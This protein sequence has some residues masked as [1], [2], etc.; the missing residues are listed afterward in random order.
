MTKLTISDMVSE[1]F[2]FSSSAPYKKLFPNTQASV[3]WYFASSPSTKAL[4]FLHS[5]TTFLFFKVGPKKPL[6]VSSITLALLMLL[7]QLLLQLV[8]LLVLLL[9]VLR[10][11]MLKYFDENDREEVAIGGEDGRN[12]FRYSLLFSSSRISCSGSAILVYIFCNSSRNGRF[13]RDN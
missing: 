1:T 9:L 8:L 6:N 10:L 5:L 7:L 11:S 3:S 4:T 13:S 12:E 2:P